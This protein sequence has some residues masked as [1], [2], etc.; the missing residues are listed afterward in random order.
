MR[1]W[2]LTQGKTYAH[3]ACVLKVNKQALPHAN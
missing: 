3:L 1:I 2:H